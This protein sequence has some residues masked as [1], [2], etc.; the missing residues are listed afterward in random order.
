MRSS[1]KY[2]TIREAFWAHVQPEPN[3][4]CWLWDGPV[5]GNG[6]GRLSFRGGHQA[7]R[8]SLLI[9][10]VGI[11]SGMEA[12]HLC[13]VRCCV[14]P[15]HLEVVT[16]QVNTQRG[17]SP[18]AHKTHCPKGHPYSGENLI[19]RKAG[20]RACRDCSRAS[21]R[22]FAAIRRARSKIE[23]SATAQQLIEVGEA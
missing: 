15:D 19:M 6:Y 14:S 13:R 18:N 17:R 11:P 4:G 23:L 5:S 12:D 16:H 21:G 10:G 2:P 1:T 20:W 22:W 3:T 9:H 7:H 8:I